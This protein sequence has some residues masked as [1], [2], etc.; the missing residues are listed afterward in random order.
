M[1]TLGSLSNTS[2]DRKRKRRVGRGISSG[3]GK[4]CNRGTKGEGARSGWRKRETYEGGQFRTYMKFPERGFSNVRFQRKLDAINLDQIDAI[5]E[6]G[7]VVSLATL[8]EK[9]FLKSKS[10][11]LKILGNGSLTKKV[12]IE[13][14]ALSKT[15][16]EKLEQAD[17]QVKLLE[18]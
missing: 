14:V 8:K 13:A 10:H 15:A 2:K 11:G 16:K 4:T 1:L 5:Y 9:G 18:V 3:A 17:I 7:E 6:N 12:K